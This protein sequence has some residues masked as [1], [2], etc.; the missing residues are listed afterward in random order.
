MII[1]ITALAEIVITQITSIHTNIMSRGEGQQ[2]PTQQEVNMEV[3]LINSLDKLRKLAIFFAKQP[4]SEIVN[5]PAQP[6]SPASGASAPATN[7]EERRQG[8]E[9]PPLSEQEQHEYS[10]LIKD[11]STYPGSSTIEF[12]GKTVSRWWLTY[13]VFQFCKHKDRHFIHD[14]QHF[15]QTVDINKLKL[16]MNMYFYSKAA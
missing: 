16:D 6:L 15:R 9:D 5:T 4:G 3:R 8:P 11:Y 13:N 1:N 14:E 7:A 2:Y 10:F 12:R